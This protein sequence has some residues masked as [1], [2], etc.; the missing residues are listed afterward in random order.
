MVRHRTTNGKIVSLVVFVSSQL[1]DRLRGRL[2]V[3]KQLPVGMYQ[4]NCFIL[5]HKETG[6]GVVIDPGDELLRIMKEISQSGLKI[7]HI[8]ITHSHFDH[9]GAAQEI[10]RITKAPI[11]IHRLDASGLNF[12]PDGYLDEGQQIGVGTYSIT[13]IH[14]PGHSPGGVCFYTNG[15]VF[16][17]DT[18]FAGSVGRTDFPGGSH[19]QLIEGVRTKIFPLGDHF[20]VYPGH[21]PATTIGKERLTNPFFRIHSQ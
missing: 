6:L 5:G 2:L 15:A 1:Q 14:T 3:L 19:T 13:V 4:A 17:G 10:G 12:K 21:G 11:L 18:L 8:L 7:G 20:R 9:T 16:T